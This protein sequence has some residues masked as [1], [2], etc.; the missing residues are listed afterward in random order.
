MGCAASADK[1]SKK[2][3]AADPAQQADPASQPAQDPPKAAEPPKQEDPPKAAEEAKPA[4]P[5]HEEPPKAEAAAAEPRV[6]RP[7]KIAVVYY[8]TYGHILQM[9]E[10]VAEGVRKGGAQVDIYQ[11]PET[12][13]EEVLEKMH[14]PPKA[15]HPLLELG[16]TLNDY[17]GFLFGIPTRYGIWPSQWKTFLDSTGQIWQSGSY[18]GKMA[19]VFTST[20]SQHGGIETTA[21]NALTFFSHHGIL[22]VPFGYAKA[23]PEL[24]NVDELVGGSPYGAGTIAAGDGSRQPSALEK[25]IA[26]KHGEHFAEMVKRHF[27]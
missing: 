19:G 11:I 2:K 24:T 26:I 27:C 1:G 15:A 3:G 9:A 7:A 12:L 10:T 18:H 16:T 4:Q 6:A 17:D 5:Q 23:F 8:S 25:T 20:A 14:A 13:P 22:F 21:F